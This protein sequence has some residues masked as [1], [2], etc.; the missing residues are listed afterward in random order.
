VV[1]LSP[2]AQLAAGRKQL[3][4][5][6]FTAARAAFEAAARSAKHRGPALV[7]LAE[8]D[9]QLGQHASAERY[10]KAAVKQGGG[11]R[12]KLVL[13]NI[14]FKLR[15]YRKAIQKYQEVLAVDENHREAK[16]NLA[17]ARQRLNQ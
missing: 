15:D 5:G 11:V 9:F 7:G 12:A 4:A 10:A 6:S 16:H 14:Y 17:A 1:R 3:L 8:V 13:A 2:Q